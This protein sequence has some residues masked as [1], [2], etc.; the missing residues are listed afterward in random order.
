MALQKDSFLKSNNINLDVVFE[1]SLTPYLNNKR[2]KNILFIGDFKAKLILKYSFN[3]N[4]WVK[5]S[6]SENSIPYDFQD[7]SSL[8]NFSNSDLLITGGC[9]YLQYKYTAKKSCFL[10][11]LIN[12]DTLEFIPFK[13]LIVPRFSHGSIIINDVPYVFGNID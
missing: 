5:M 12:N 7:Y 11:H 10:I 4:N 9:N 13:P 8:A 2:L 1:M 3:D 6:L